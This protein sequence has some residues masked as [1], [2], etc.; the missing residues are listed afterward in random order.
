[1]KY[2]IILNLLFVVGCKQEQHKFLAN[3]VYTSSSEFSSMDMSEQ[4]NHN[5]KKYWDNWK[6]GGDS[7]QWRRVESENNQRNIDFI[8]QIRTTNN[9]QGNQ[10]SKL[11][12]IK[13]TNLSGEWV[14][15]GSNN[16]SGRIYSI[17][18]DVSTNRLV[19]ISSSGQIW[20]MDDNSRWRSLNDGFRLFDTFRNSNISTKYGGYQISLVNSGEN[21]IIVG[22]S[23]QKAYYSNSGELWQEVQNLVRN[24]NTS[25]VNV[26]E[27]GNKVYLLQY[28]RYGQDYYLYQSNDLALGFDLL[29]QR[30]EETDIRTMQISYTGN[31]DYIFYRMT[32]GTIKIKQIINDEL[33]DI[34]IP[35]VDYDNYTGHFNIAAKDGFLYLAMARGNE[36][37]IYL[38]TDKGVSW[39]LMGVTPDTIYGIEINNFQ[40][41]ASDRNILYFGSM[42]PMVSYDR[43]VNW[44]NI[45]EDNYSQ[46]PIESLHVDTRDVK[47]YLMDDGGS[48][49]FIANDGGVYS[50]KNQMH[51]VQNIS[52]EGLNVSQYYDVL[53]AKFNP[54][55]II[56]GAQDQGVHINQVYSEY[57]M[58]YKIISGGDGGHMVS[59]DEGRSFWRSGNNGIAY[60]PNGGQQLPNSTT[61]FS[62]RG[63]NFWDFVN[64]PTQH[65][66]LWLPKIATANNQPEKVYIGLNFN[67]LPGLWS[68][69]YD[70]EQDALITEKNPFDFSLGAQEEQLIVDVA[71]SPLNADYRYVVVQNRLNTTTIN[72]NLETNVKVFS[73]ID[74]GENWDVLYLNDFGINLAGVDITPSEIKLG[75]YYITGGQYSKDESIV[76]VTQNNGNSFTNISSGMPRTYVNEI[77]ESPNK[78]Y[79]FAATDAGPYAYDNKKA[80]WYSMHGVNSP[81]QIYSGVEFIEALNIVRFSTFGRGLWDFKIPKVDSMIIDGTFSGVYEDPNFVGKGVILNINSENSATIG[82]YTYGKD[83]KLK[84]IVGQHGVINGQ[85]I[86]FSHL[87]IYSGTGLGDDYREDEVETRNWGKLTITFDTCERAW[88]SYSE[89]LGVAQYEIDPNRNGVLKVFEFGRGYKSLRKI[90]SVFDLECGNNNA[91]ANQANW[92]GIYHNPLRRGEFLFLQQTE[93]N[94]VT[95]KLFTYHNGKQMWLD[96]NGISKSDKIVIPQVNITRGGGFGPIDNQILTNHWG[97]IFIHGDV[98]NDIVIEYDGVFYGDGQFEMENLVKPMGLDCN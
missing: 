80:N 53:T 43:G 44:T 15:K 96:L 12:K 63:M 78:Q 95:G 85:S 18:Y 89:D 54:H 71:I 81:V 62:S 47:S 88:M 50:S 93:S 59:G 6:H 83:G 38:T 24:W 4:T 64:P 26:W 11:T 55:M 94:R 49:S 56:A 31:S 19:A 32:N 14:E 52:I 28:D 68:V 16:I 66:F 67:G 57:D 21:M 41:D 27:R 75:R 9:I 5:S 84:W 76:Y 3:D 45:T 22:G 35:A 7:T 34:N 13:G 33:V 25:I 72:P 87:R 73:S 91:Q 61:G 42:L 90:S 29:L 58:G 30:S 65:G 98:C 69:T 40:V 8:K 74:G 92:S 23:P 2:L 51:S 39:N 37:D 46:D 60:F 10:Y 1:M 77:V 82:W 97:D 20:E 17:D 70:P 36:T 86:E 79:L 48:I